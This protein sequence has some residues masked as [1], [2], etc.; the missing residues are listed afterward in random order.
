M[1]LK[2]WELAGMVTLFLVFT[3]FAAAGTMQEN[4]AEKLVRL[5]VIANSDTQADPGLKLQVRDAV[6]EITEQI[7]EDCR[8]TGETRQ[9]LRQHLP[10]IEEAAQGVVWEE[11][12]DYTVKA[13]LKEEFYPSK[14]YCNF[15]LPAGYY[16]GLQVKIGEARGHNWW[17]V[18]FPPLCTATATEESF[19]G[20]TEEE[21]CFVRQDGTRY[22]LRFKAAELVEQLRYH[23]GESR[24]KPKK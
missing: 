20:F 10:E 14:A 2:K 1:K 9:A 11:G 15:A 4:V 13:E 19:T 3:Y 16:T 22:A 7:S 21:T 6:L 23:L 17:C 24:E 18:V 8:N 12:Y 5:H